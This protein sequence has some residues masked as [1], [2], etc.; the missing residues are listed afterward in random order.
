MEILETIQ[1][2]RRDK[3]AMPFWKV[4][5]P[6]IQCAEILLKEAS[7]QKD[8]E[9]KYNMQLCEARRLWSVVSTILGSTY[10]PSSYPQ[11]MVENHNWLPHD[12]V[13]RASVLYA[14]DMAV[15]AVVVKLNRTRKAQWQY[16]GGL[17]VRKYE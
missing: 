2:L 12:G 13:H 11:I 8:G 17:W 1:D 3:R 5:T 10:D 6:Y 15:P 16:D 7:L 4:C 14:A 9:N